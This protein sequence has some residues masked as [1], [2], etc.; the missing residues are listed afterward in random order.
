MDSVTT[1]IK[2]HRKFKKKKGGKKSE[3]DVWINK[4]INNSL[5]DTRTQ[6]VT[7]RRF[8]ENMDNLTVVK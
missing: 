6:D 4:E 2:Q 7:L 3:G 8:L 1:K 5:R